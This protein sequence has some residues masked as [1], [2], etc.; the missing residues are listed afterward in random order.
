MTLSIRLQREKNLFVTKQTR[1]TNFKKVFFQKKAAYIRQSSVLAFFLLLS[2]FVRLLSSLTH[3]SL[4]RSHIRS[5]TLQKCYA[6]LIW[7]NPIPQNLERKKLRWSFFLLSKF[8]CVANLS[9]FFSCM[10]RKKPK[11]F[12]KKCGRF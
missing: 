1:P 4:N 6:K 9:C 8:I 3:G 5:F 12:R 11:F 2:I 7:G 10:L